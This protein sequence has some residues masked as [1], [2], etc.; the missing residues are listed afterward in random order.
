MN[1][2]S[3]CILHTVTY[4]QG[5]QV[6]FEINSMAR[7]PHVSKLLNLL[8]ERN[9]TEKRPSFDLGPVYLFVGKWLEIFLTHKTLSLIIQFVIVPNYKFMRNP[10]HILGIFLISQSS[11]SIIRIR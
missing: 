8:T 4:F 3:I 5:F 9:G 2:I 6:V 1:V 11:F 10:H 7:I